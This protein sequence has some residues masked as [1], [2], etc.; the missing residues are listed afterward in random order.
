MYRFSAFKSL[1]P[2]EPMDHT[3]KAKWLVAVHLETDPAKW[4]HYMTSLTSHYGILTG[5]RFFIF[6]KDL[7]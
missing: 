5:I 4:W 2:W 6:R 3:G 1:L 7:I